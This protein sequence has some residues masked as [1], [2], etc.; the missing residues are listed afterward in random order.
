MKKRKFSPEAEQHHNFLIYDLSSALPDYMLA[1]HINRNLN[2]HFGREKDFEVHNPST[3]NIENYSLYQFEEHKNQK[4]Y[5]VNNLKNENP[6]MK[7]YFIFVEGSF[8][9]E[10]EEEFLQHLRSIPDVLNVNPISLSGS[11]SGK[12]ASKKTIDIINALLTDLE[13]HISD[14]TRQKT[15][16]KLNVTPSKTGG[17]KKLYD[18]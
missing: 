5:L 17:I 6:L 7:S 8:H 18:L 2:I 16:K 13:F 15:E 10:M 3:G 4:Y 1:F 14:L 9:K 12:G 11:P